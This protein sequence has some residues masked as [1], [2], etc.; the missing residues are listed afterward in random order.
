[1]KGK[2]IEN[3]RLKLTAFSGEDVYVLKQCSKP[4]IDHFAIIGF[5]VLLIFIGCFISATTFTFS[6]FNENPFISIPF[7]ILW[8]CIITVIYLLLL[9]TISPPTLPSKYKLKNKDVVVNDEHHNK[10]FTL[11]MLLRLS[12]MTLLAVIIAQPLNV[13][14][15]S[16]NIESSL[17]K[18]KQLQKANMTIAA[19]SMFV[20]DE[21]KIKADFEGYASVK[22]TSKELELVKKEVLEIDNKISSDRM[23]IS[24]AYQLLDSITKYQNKS[25]VF[26]QNKKQDSL[27]NELTVLLNIEAQSDFDYQSELAEMT[28]PNIKVV[29]EFNIYK[30]ML[31]NIITNKIENYS[32]IESLISKSNFYVQKIKILLNENIFSWIITLFV[33]GLFLLPI[34]M[35]FLVRNKRFYIAKR[36]IE[37]KIVLQAYDDF[38]I[39]YS[40]ILEAKINYINQT[41]L[42]RLEVQLH[43]IKAIDAVKYDSFL[44]EFED[45]LCSEKIDFYENWKN[46]PF[47]TIRLT[48]NTKFN[49]EKKFLELL[50]K[51]VDA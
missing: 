10:F 42:K 11:S 25:L 35:K 50:Y 45:K 30:S 31:D 43:S 22:L 37:E 47:R 18:F 29:D 23:F 33:I 3:I 21:L 12:F 14:F 9:Y 8:A 15:L 7:G 32:K 20:L 5:F 41:I 13:Y 36:K 48:D 1:M 6:L 51:N 26:S 24:K 39:K 46:P 44:N 27:V 16:N 40:E 38:R 2:F 49:S 28:T 34:R 4:I 17:D 19:D